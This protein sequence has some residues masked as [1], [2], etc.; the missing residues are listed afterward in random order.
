MRLGRIPV[1]EPRCIYDS[2]LLVSLSIQLRNGRRR[3][4]DEYLVALLLV[5]EL[6]T[7]IMFRAE[8]QYALTHNYI[9]WHINDINLI[10]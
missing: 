1:I 5:V 9:S 7:E 3:R 6:D 4:I 2:L 10:P 8:I